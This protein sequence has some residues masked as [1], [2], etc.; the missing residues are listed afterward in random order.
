MTCSRILHKMIMEND[1]VDGQYLK[2]RNEFE[3]G[4]SPI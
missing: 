4:Y 1:A 3:N 2:D